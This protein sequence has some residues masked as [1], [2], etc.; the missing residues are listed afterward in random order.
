MARKYNLQEIDPRK[1][2]F[3]PENPRNESEEVI[4][5]D[6]S[7]EQLK[8]SVY[9]HGVLV[10]IVIRKQTGGG[11]PY[12]LV[13]GERRLRAALAT[14]VDLVPAHIAES[15]ETMDDIVQAF[16]IHMLRKQWQP[17][18]MTRALKKIMEHLTQ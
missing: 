15:T 4:N 17:V 9:K 11:K 8:D 16:H 1:I 2:D 13:D 3:D 12:K 5:T 18:A 6:P 10:T 14:G 7:F